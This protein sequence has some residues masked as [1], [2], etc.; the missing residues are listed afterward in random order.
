MSAEW[1]YRER[2]PP[3]EL[4]ALADCFWTERVGDRADDPGARVLPDGCID[5][6]WM[7]GRPPFVAGPATRP[8]FT[9]LPT[10]SRIVGVRF[11]PAMA[12]AV[13]GAP[14]TDLLDAEV[15]LRDLWGREARLSLSLLDRLD[16]YAS[17]EERFRAVRALIGGRLDRGNDVDGSVVAAT[18]WLADHPDGS[19]GLL[20]ARAGL[21]E[22]QLRRRFEAAVGY[23]PKTF[24]RIVRFQ[25]WLQQA[26]ETSSEQRSLSDL[27]AEAGYADQAHL[28][29]EVTRLAGLSPAA[30][31]SER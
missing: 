13:L 7:Q 12:T 31:L 3:P 30:L 4:A 6:V 9:S 26:R 15:P 18:R 25:Q 22:R 27:A 29:R 28:T 23:G 20:Y 2:Q 10:G 11:R 5:I 14:A 1:V 24:Q 19:L 21:S 8:M 17:V 16:E